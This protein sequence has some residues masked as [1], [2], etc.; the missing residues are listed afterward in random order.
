MV[1]V[2]GLSVVSRLLRVSGSGVLGIVREGE[3]VDG[4]LFS[5]LV[6]SAS[7]GALPPSSIRDSVWSSAAETMRRIC[8]SFTF[9]LV[10]LLLLSSCLSSSF[11]ALSFLTSSSP[12]GCASSRISKVR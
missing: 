3:E 7:S 1:W 12:L 4:L 6:S 11:S 2:L 5:S 10:L 8:L 9:L